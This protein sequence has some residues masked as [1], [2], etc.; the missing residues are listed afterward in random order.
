MSTQN[1]QSNP[2]G[3]LMVSPSTEATTQRALPPEVEGHIKALTSRDEDALPANTL[4][5][6]RASFREY[7]KG[8]KRLDEVMGLAPSAS[9]RNWRT[10]DRLDLRNAWLV[11]AFELLDGPSAYNRCRQLS[12][13]IHSFQEAFWPGLE[14]REAP[15]QELTPF[16]QALFFAF[17]ASPGE[18]PQSWRRLK[19]IV[20][21]PPP[22]AGT[23]SILWHVQADTYDE[24]RSTKIDPQTTIGKSNMT[25]G[26]LAVLALHAWKGSPVLQ[27]RHQGDAT[28]YW[29]RVLRQ[30]MD[31]DEDEVPGLITEVLSVEQINSALKSAGVKSL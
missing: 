2:W 4:Q 18:V 14:D 10:I 23:S 6:L 17:K 21:N 9:Q 5:W 31:C 29:Q 16:R 28:D 1:F 19:E 30:A 27:E 11:R 3:Q 15:P 25:L 22:A 12:D 8:L 13:Q 26:H 7:V 24:S 20:Q